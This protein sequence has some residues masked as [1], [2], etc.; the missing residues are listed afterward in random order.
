MWDTVGVLGVPQIELVGMNLYDP[1]HREFSFVDTK[2]PSNLEYAYQALALD[3]D[4]KPY[5][6]TLW[7]SPKS[8]DRSIL[9][10]LKQCWFPGVHSSV[11]G[12]YEDTSI[13]D[14]TIAWMVTQLSRHLAFDP[15]YILQ[16]KK[17]NEQFYINEKVPVCS[18]GM[19]LIPRADTGTLNALLGKATRTPGDYYAMDPVTGRPTKERLTDTCEFMHPSVQYR[20][21]NHGPGLAPSS[22][23]PATGDYQPKALAGWKYIGP[24]KPWRDGDVRGIG[25]DAEKW[26]SYG[27]WMTTRRN[28][29]TVFIVEEQ[30]DHGTPEINL[31]EA[32]G[33]DVAA[34]VLNA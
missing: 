28:G 26:D 12:G 5:S 14:I 7:E 22:T 25:A 10:R 9:K 21:S 23:K 30:I 1:S 29:D 3:E 8:D 18:W 24:N 19:G 4:R 27:K 17:M 32:W 6:P 11:G 16:Q 20:I 34:K 15:G 33:P 31:L 2:V 13:S